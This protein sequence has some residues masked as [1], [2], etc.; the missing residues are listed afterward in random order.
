MTAVNAK[1]LDS[2]NPRIPEEGHQFGELLWDE[3]K[4]LLMGPQE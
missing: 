2:G 1:E 3:G 4:L